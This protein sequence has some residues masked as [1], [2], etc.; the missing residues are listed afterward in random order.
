LTQNDWE[1]DHHPSWSPDG[2]QIVFCSNRTGYQQIWLMNADG[3]NPRN[4]SPW[5]E[6]ND[7]D[8]VW[9]K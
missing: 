5:A 1:W 2:T 9:I 7:W 6:W 3:S 8:P 4:I